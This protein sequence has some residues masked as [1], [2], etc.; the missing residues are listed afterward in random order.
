ML[1]APLRL[2]QFLENITPFYVKKQTSL[3]VKYTDNPFRTS[4]QSAATKHECYMKEMKSA[5]DAKETPSA[6]ENCTR[7]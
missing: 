1:R 2:I 4:P 3:F 7:L 5:L 6:V